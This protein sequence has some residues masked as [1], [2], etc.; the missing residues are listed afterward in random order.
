MCVNARRTNECSYDAYVGSLSRP[1]DS[2]R[3]NE[4]EHRPARVPRLAGT[5]DVSSAAAASAA[6]SV[7]VGVVEDLQRRVERLEDA[8][9][10]AYGSMRAGSADDGP[11]EEQQQ[12]LKVADPYIPGTVEF[13]DGRSKFRPVGHKSAI[14]YRFTDA[15]TFIGKKVND[16]SMVKSLRSLRRHFP[17]Q[18]Q[19]QSLNH[20][21]HSQKLLLPRIYELIPSKRECDA[22]VPI[23]F[24][25]FQLLL[26]VLD[27]ET[28]DRQYDHFWS[29]PV[30]Q[31]IGSSFAPC[32]LLVTWLAS[33][34]MGAQAPAALRQPAELVDDWLHGRI[35][36]DLSDLLTIQIELLLLCAM[37]IGGVI[38]EQ[39]YRVCGRVLRS[40]MICGLQYDPGNV[41]QIPR[42][43][44]DIR[45]GIWNTV[46]EIDLSASLL[47][48][49]PCAAG[50]DDFTCLPPANAGRLAR[51]LHDTLPM[52]LEAA[53]LVKH[54]HGDIVHAA[55]VVEVCESAQ[56]EES[57]D[58]TPPIT[59]A[60]FDVWCH[61][62]ILGSAR[63][64]LEGP[65]LSPGR[66]ASCRSSLRLLKHM[67]LLAA[68][69]NEWIF[70]FAISHQDI[71]Q[72]ILMVCLVLRVRNVEAASS[73]TPQGKSPRSVNSTG[74]GEAEIGE[75]PFQ[76][77]ALGA[78][79]RRSLD[80]LL[81]H[82][83]REQL[84]TYLKDLLVLSVAIDSA[85]HPLDTAKQQ[86][87]MDRG[88]T[89]VV[90][91]LGERGRTSD[92][93]AAVAA[94]RVSDARMEPP[95]DGMSA[96]ERML[97]GLTGQTGLG[98]GVASSSSSS[99]GSGVGDP[100]LEF[101]ST[102]W[103]N[104]GSFSLDFGLPLEQNF[105]MEDGFFNAE[106]DPMN[107]AAF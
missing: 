43:E 46:V 3:D 54:R 92:V 82:I 50:P 80:T 27:R 33:F 61:R 58:D 72:S 103:L 36:R 53:R 22:L 87:A 55:R 18:P 70:Y 17:K 63:L 20:R 76:P 84:G 5:D 13:K 48:G 7:K 26:F 86:A 2:P 101:D 40:S 83:P 16:P 1:S 77:E 52:R 96:T 99:R 6:A 23:Y 4:F 9:A 41:T 79:A 65:A 74:A 91:T 59:K 42:E 29:L 62:S 12:S 24:N 44:V 31:R 28:F 106:G 49:L 45:R 11:T 69:P 94:S 97:G 104:A 47:C 95:P 93:G 38:I 66:L 25:G 14:L 19:T 98:G 73:N 57:S 78:V 64:L 21:Q 67:E 68:R 34:G 51:T 10:S 81:A 85:H 75:M 30:E 100:M 71:F 32:L 105:G 88:F 60:I 37:Q 39:V 15:K 35:S 107:W 102:A 8:M 90:E 56:A 89:R